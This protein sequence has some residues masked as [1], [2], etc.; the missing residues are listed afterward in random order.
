MIE[1]ILKKKIIEHI[2]TYEGPTANFNELYGNFTTEV[3][4]VCQEFV[5]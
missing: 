3:L 4:R 5:R 1:Q 2:L